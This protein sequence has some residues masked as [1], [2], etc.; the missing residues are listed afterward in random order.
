MNFFRRAPAAVIAAED[1]LPGRSDAIKITGKHYVNGTSMLP[2]FP[3]Q[4][5]TIVFGMGCFWGA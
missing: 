4:M 5:E 3:A 2:P 1:A